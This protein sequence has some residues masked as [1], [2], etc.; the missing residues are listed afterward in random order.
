MIRDLETLYPDLSDE[1]R[2]IAAR[3]WDLLDVIRKNYYHPD[4][5]GS[6]SI[7]SV[8]PALVPE[9]AYTDLDVQSGDGAAATYQKLATD[10]D[11]DPIERDQIESAL[12]DYCARD[13]LAMVKVLECLRSLASSI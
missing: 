13:T 2:A 7:K 9:L 4:F 8:V 5:H 1:L 12:K 6:Y 11:L 10:P 3:I